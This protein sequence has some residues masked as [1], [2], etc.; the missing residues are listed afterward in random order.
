MRILILGGTTEARQLAQRLAGRTDLA[1]VLSLA[2]RTAAPAQQ[3]VPVRVGGFGGAEGLADYLAEQKIDALIDATHPYAAIIS[4]NAIVAARR[5]R[6]RLLALH[7]PGWVAV[8]GDAIAH[9]EA[10][11]SPSPLV[12][13]GRGGGSEGCGAQVVQTPTPTPDPSP[14]EPG[15]SRGSA[16]QPSDRSRQQPTSVGGGEKKALAAGDRWTEV[17]DVAGAVRALGDASRR[18]FLALGRKE[19]EPFAEAPQHHYLVRSVDPVVPPLA[20]PHAVYVTGRGPFDEADERAMLEQHRIDVVV[21]K[22]SGGAATYGKIAA[23]RALGVPVIMLR[24]P[25]MPDVEAVETVDDAVAWL[26]HALALVTAR[27]V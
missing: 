9:H 22:N 27:G 6:V 5:V 11:S 20:V 4:A 14:A 16:T 2:G 24:R 17:G 13:E 8:A 26:D 3:P 1:V 18:V 10:L 21:A 19:I 15:Y 23:A 25:A 7:R 12:G